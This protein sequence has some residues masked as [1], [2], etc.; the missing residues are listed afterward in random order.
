MASTYTNVLSNEELDYLNN[1]PEVLVAKASLNSRPSGIVYF[2]I[3]ITN[4]IRD[5]LLSR[6]GLNPY[7]MD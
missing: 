2:S 3:T 1:H 6:F 5:T 7:E 4:E